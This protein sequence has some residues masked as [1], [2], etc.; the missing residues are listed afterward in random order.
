MKVKPSLKENMEVAQTLQSLAVEAAEI[1]MLLMACNGELSPELEKRLDVNAQLL[2]QKTDNYNFIIESIESAA[3]Q[4][5][6]RKDAFAIQEK[7]LTNERDRMWNR[8]KLAMKEMDRT[9][10]RGR[11]YRFQLQRSKPKLI[12][13]ESLLP[14]QFKMIVQETKPDKAKIEAVLAEGLEIP[15]VTLEESGTLKVYENSE[16]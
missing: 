3:A 7:R 12:I 2:L 16:E 5:K 9:E 1:S 15:G 4:M 13:D 11:Y 6:R 10:I 8:I 14:D